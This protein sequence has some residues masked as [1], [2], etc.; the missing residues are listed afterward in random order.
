MEIF[1]EEHLQNGQIDTSST[2]EFIVPESRNPEGKK[3]RKISVFDRLSAKKE[4][5]GKPYGRRPIG[6]VF[7]R[8]SE[9]E[10]SA[11]A[12]ETGSEQRQLFTHF[13]A[14]YGTWRDKNF[15]EKQI[16]TINQVNP[17]RN[18]MWEISQELPN[19]NIKTGPRS[20]RVVLVERSPKPP[21][22]RKLETLCRE[23]LESI[24][25]P[26][27]VEKTHAE[28]KRIMKKNFPKAHEEVYE[29]LIVKEPMPMT[30]TE[31]ARIFI[32]LCREQTGNPT[33]AK[34]NQIAAAAHAQ[35]MREINRM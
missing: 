27:M 17:E 16:E 8:L 20:E 33:L 2:G 19:P 5:S 32:R 30:T 14:T 7:G 13:N 24:E 21:E 11:G 29:E 23:T 34:L 3:T 26:E 4:R 9:K 22:V 18:Q 1:V 31:H 28:I 35:I 10:P 25:G 6:S 12:M 15:N